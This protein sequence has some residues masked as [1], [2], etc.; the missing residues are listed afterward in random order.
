VP[1][2]A[3]IVGIVDVY[4]ALTSHRP[5]RKALTGDEAARMLMEE[6]FEGKFLKMH[7]DAFLDSQQITTFA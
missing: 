6:V 3:Q 1:L 4:D 5:Y 7:V 2:L